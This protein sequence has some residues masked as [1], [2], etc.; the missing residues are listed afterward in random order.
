MLRKQLK[1]ASNGMPPHY[2]MIVLQAI[3]M[4]LQLLTHAAT[5]LCPCCAL[6]DARQIRG[7][8]FRLAQNL[9]T[10]MQMHMQL[11]LYTCMYGLGQL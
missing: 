2:W 5:P 1:H 6:M 11:Q 9:I 4:L 3:Q 7:Q 8:A 10:H